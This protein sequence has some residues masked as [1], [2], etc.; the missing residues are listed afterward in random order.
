MRK[1]TKASASVYEVSTD[2]N[3][4]QDG[5]RSI[6][7]DSLSDDESDDDE[8][9]DDVDEN[10]NLFSNSKRHF[11]YEVVISRS[12]LAYIRRLNNIT[13]EIINEK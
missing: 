11:F 10:P 7:T 4:P 13:L 1:K 6:D 9:D 12:I 5:A 3:V 2:V 8:D